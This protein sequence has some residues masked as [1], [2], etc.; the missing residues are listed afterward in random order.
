M[1]L[2]TE[3]RHRGMPLLGICFGCQM[4]NVWRG[5]TLVQDLLP[6]PVNHAAGPAVA[7]AHSAL[8]A[9]D[10]LLGGVLLADA[11]AAAE[12]S[13]RRSPA[14]AAD[15]HKPP[16]GGDGSRRWPARRGAVARGRGR[17]GGGDAG[18]RGTGVLAGGAVASGAY[19]GDQRGV[20][21]AVCAAGGR[22]R[23]LPP[24]GGWAQLMPALGE[25]AIGELLEPFLPAVWPAE[26]A[27]R[28]EL[29]PRL[30]AYLE[31]LR[32][33]NGRT[34]LTAIREPRA[35]VER[36]F[37][38]S[39]FAGFG[40]LAAAGESGTLLDVGSGAGFPGLPM[41]LLLP[42]W[43]VMLAESQGKKAAFLQ[44][45]V[46]T[47][48]SN[49]SVWPRRVELLGY[50]VEFDAVSLR[51]VDRPELALAGARQ[52]VRPGGWLCELT[53]RGSEVPEGAEEL[54]LPKSED[55]VLRLSRLG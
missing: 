14:A 8:V 13:A 52:R 6:L 47:L 15:Q 20:T 7:V 18:G 51:A 1:L 45:A 10:S 39:L 24:P 11:D 19:R 3:A 29:L 25:A 16:P 55:R 41:A 54:P 5:G 2:L 40:L 46:R 30:S 44:E 38:E 12:C 34:N 48:A 31:L 49:A 21:G 37:G 32:V 27:T 50:E 23:G 22:G 33:W 17:G 4:L 26:A 36:H 53:S 9:A 42:G 28:A 35:I 43:L